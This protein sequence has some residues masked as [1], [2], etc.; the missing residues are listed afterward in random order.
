[1]NSMSGEVL[2][3]TDG[4]SSLY[5]SY[6]SMVLSAIIWLP[7]GLRIQRNTESVNLPASSAKSMRSVRT[8]NARAHR[9]ITHLCVN[10]ALH[11]GGCYIGCLDGCHT[12]FTRPT[13]SANLRR[14]GVS[15]NSLLRTDRRQD[16]ESEA[17]TISWNLSSDE[18]PEVAC[19]A[20][21]RG[22]PRGFR[23][24]RRFGGGSRRV[25]RQLRLRH[26]AVRGPG[27]SATV[28]RWRLG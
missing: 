1:M 16:P 24:R 20:E 26:A 6:N 18:V 10:A 28:V 11:G 19:A 17:A 15:R 12:N 2:V 13:S 5:E 27:A 3:P 7:V 23:I 22:V 8:D 4:T 9:S 21:T 14:S 25:R